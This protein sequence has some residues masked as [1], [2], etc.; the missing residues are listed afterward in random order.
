MIRGLLVIFCLGCSVVVHAD[1]G[2]T[3]IE[4]AYAADQERLTVLGL[5]YEA[6]EFRALAQ[7]HSA[8]TQLASESFRRIKIEKDLKNAEELADKDFMTKE[9]LAGAHYK[10]RESTNNIKRLELEILQAKANMN[11]QKLKVL[12]EGMS[13]SDQRA[14]IVEASIEEVQYVVQGLKFSLDT[15]QFELDLRRTKLQNGERLFKNKFISEDELEERRLYTDLAEKNV[16][17]INLQIEAANAALKG[18][19]ASRKRLQNNPETCC[20]RSN[21]A[22]EEA[23]VH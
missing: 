17:G 12:N 11:V 16:R 4:P 18:L 20:S 10:F 2:W 22:Q 6:L 9:A 19:E 1:D 8:K 13:K 15:A 7:W 23:M 5:Q 21:K 3:P 14:G